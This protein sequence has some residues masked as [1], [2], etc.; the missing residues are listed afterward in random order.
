[1]VMNRQLISRITTFIDNHQLIPEGSTIILGMSGGPDSVFLFHYLVTLKETR[2]FNLITAHLNHGWRSSAHIDEQFCR[3]LGAQFGIT[4]IIEHATS[5]L[6]D[7]PWTG[8]K[9]EQARIARRIFFE[10]IAGEYQEAR[11]ALAHHQD[12]QDETFF[13]RLIRGAGLQGLKGMA[14]RSGLYVRPLLCARKDE[15]L[16]YLEEHTLAY[17]LDSTN[18]DDT[19]LRN[20]IRHRVLPALR[21]CDQRFP[22]SLQQVLGHLAEADDFCTDLAEKTLQ[23]LV[24][25]REDGSWMNIAAWQ[26][27]HPFLQKQVLLSWLC[28]ANVSFTPS[29]GLFNEIMRFLNQPQGG[30]HLLYGRWYIHKQNS[31]ARITGKA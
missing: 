15:L 3:D 16:T 29:Q 22:G 27:L 6:Q 5:L 20:R 1:M 26:Q 30:K 11:I 8:S 14:P 19:Y 7:I 2:S 31:Q 21:L 10:K 9:E 12:D 24:N 17:V 4:T 13:I 23:Q 25:L 28:K 18:V